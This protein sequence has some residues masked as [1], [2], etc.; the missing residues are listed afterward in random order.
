M[1][2]TGARAED[3]GHTLGRAGGSGSRT[4]CSLETVNGVAAALCAEHPAPWPAMGRA[5]RLM[6]R[7]H[8]GG[9]AP[10]QSVW[11]TLASAGALT[12]VTAAPPARSALHEARS[13]FFFLSAGA[14]G[15]QPRPMARPRSKRDEIAAQPGVGAARGSW[16]LDRKGSRAGSAVGR[17]CGP[18]LG[19]R[20]PLLDTEH[21][22]GLV[23]G[24]DLWAA[25]CGRQGEEGRKL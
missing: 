15:P 7:P 5:E 1:L 14:R 3:A 4:S 25:F 20:F 24:S 9:Y 16:L 21:H 12:R 19:P 2:D 13:I 18:G 22:H 17:W 23:R 8:S 6:G 10:V 11:P